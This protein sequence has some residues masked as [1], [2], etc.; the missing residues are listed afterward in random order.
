ML[1]SKYRC[2]EENGARW[3]RAVVVT[4]CLAGAGFQSRS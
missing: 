3:S 4:W 1:L 2:D